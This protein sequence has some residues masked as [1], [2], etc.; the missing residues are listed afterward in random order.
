VEQQKQ[1]NKVRK[2]LLAA[3]AAA[4]IA[5]PAAAR[6]HSGYVGLD[7]GFLFPT[8]T[9]LHVDGS[10]SYYGYYLC[11]Y[12][13]N[14]NC[15][16][17]THYKTG[18]D[19]DVVGGYDFGMFRLE[20]ELGYKRAKHDRYSASGGSL[21]ADGRTTA[22]SAMINGLVDFGN[23]KGLNFSIGGGIGVAHT[24]YRF[25]LDDADSEIDAFSETISGSKF[26]WQIIAEARLPVSRSLDLGLKYRYFDGGRVRDTFD[27][28]DGGTIGFSSRLRSHSLLASL[29]YNF[30]PPAPP[31]PPP[32]AAP[33]PPATQT[34]PDGSVI[35]ATAMCPPPPPP[36]PP[37]PAPEQR[38]ERGQ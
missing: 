3:A 10:N 32:P 18:Y 33:P 31:P 34:C 5:T 23:D 21:D 35:P 36:P 12:S 13:S 11:Y 24:K 15:D 22:T 37:P 6:D 19:I 16:L 20:G 1:G 17:K 7:A 9:N 4:A 30:A 2:Y 14:Y 28:G 8:N 29:R 26:A 38:G 25:S 27:D